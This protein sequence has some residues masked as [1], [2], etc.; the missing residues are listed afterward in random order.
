LK[1]AT[2]YGKDNTVL[3]TL[4]RGFDLSLPSPGLERGKKGKDS[5]NA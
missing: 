2:V 5:S 4:Q 3:N 1:V